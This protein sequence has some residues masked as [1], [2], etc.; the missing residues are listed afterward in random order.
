M[1][2]QTVGMC[3]DRGATT[4]QLIGKQ[5]ENNIRQ[6]G[7][8]RM[9]QD[10]C[11]FSAADRGW[12]QGTV[13]NGSAPH[14]FKKRRQKDRRDRGEKGP[15]RKE[16]WLMSAAKPQEAGRKWQY[17]SGECA[18]YRRHSNVEVTLQII[19]NSQAKTQ[20]KYKEQTYLKQQY[21]MK[22][23]THTYK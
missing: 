19:I 12:W 11:T 17:A 10:R 14:G 2:L 3:A 4:W 8:G 5:S 13:P 1:G 23:N 18:P 20:A 15:E 7:F 6:K 22:H 16:K 21:H 9:D